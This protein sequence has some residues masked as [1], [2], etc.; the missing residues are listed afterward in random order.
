MPFTCSAVQD[1]TKD[2]WA[3]L[4]DRMDY[5]PVIDVGFQSAEVA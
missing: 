2:G 4:W 3:R 5:Q 1:V